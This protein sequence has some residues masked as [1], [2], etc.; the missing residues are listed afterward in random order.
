MRPELIEAFEYLEEMLDEQYDYFD[1]GYEDE[2]TLQEFYDQVEEDNPYYSWTPIAN[3]EYE[4]KAECDIYQKT[5]TPKK[6]PTV[7]NEDNLL[8]GEFIPY[9]RSIRHNW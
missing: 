1:P 7:I 6:L 4:W 3:R 9:K 2:P 8:S 5:Q